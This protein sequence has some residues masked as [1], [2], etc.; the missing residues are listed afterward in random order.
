MT[1]LYETRPTPSLS[2]PQFPY[3][4]WDSGPGNYLGREILLL[5][6]FTQTVWVGAL[7]ATWYKAVFHKCGNEEERDL[8]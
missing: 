7:Y 4:D 8:F 1:F 2:G 3:L 5:M 6:N